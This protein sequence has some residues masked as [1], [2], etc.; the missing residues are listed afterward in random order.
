MKYLESVAEYRNKRKQII[1]RIATTETRKQKRGQD[2][3]MQGVAT[4][5][6]AC[7]N[8]DELRVIN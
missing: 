6:S 1:T 5:D 8:C 7:Y 2:Q 4:V 3:R